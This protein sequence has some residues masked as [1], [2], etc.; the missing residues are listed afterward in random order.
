MKHFFSTLFVVF[1]ATSMMAQTGLTCED[2]IP[3]DENYTA[4]IT[5]TKL[6]LNYFVS[7]FF[8]LT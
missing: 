2:P 1:F 3:V 6:C 4:T 8:K 7:I 5:D